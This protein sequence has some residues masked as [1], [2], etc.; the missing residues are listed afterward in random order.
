MKVTCL[1]ILLL[2]TSA[3]AF[4]NGVVKDDRRRRTRGVP[5]N[6]RALATGEKPE[7]GSKG[8]KG[9]AMKGMGK[10]GCQTLKLKSPFSEVSA[11]SSQTAVG[12]TL[13]FP[14]YDFYT[15]EPVGT[16]TK[17]STDIFVGGEFADCTNTASYNLGFDDSL[18]Y[19]FVSQIMV[20]GTCFGTS[21]AITGGT[22]KYAC[23]A[24][25]GALIDG[26][27]FFASELTICNTCA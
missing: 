11:G 3:A 9:K 20:S 15:D 10:K 4:S 19:P 13:T 22:G 12:D 17:S 25:Y 14:V 16:F 2:A 18:E 7:K 6:N 8:M 27:D 5:D 23:A 26:L 21:N 1:S 24:G